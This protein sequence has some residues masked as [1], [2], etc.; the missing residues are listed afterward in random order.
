MRKGISAPQAGPANIDKSKVRHWFPNSRHCAATRLASAA[1]WLCRL[2]T[3]NNPV[4]PGG[5][6]S[7]DSEFDREWE[8]YSRGIEDEKPRRSLALD[9]ID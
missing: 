9:G 2:A 7:L 4:V 6:V 5:C 8:C 1:M 3:D